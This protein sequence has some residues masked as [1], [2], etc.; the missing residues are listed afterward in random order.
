MNSIR[1]TGLILLLVFLL[2]AVF[3][4]AYEIS[5]LN[6]NEEVINQIYQNQLDAILYSV[7]Q[8]SDDVTS[9]WIS[10][11]EAG[12]KE[13]DTNDTI[14]EKIYELLQFNPGISYIFLA[15]TTNG[16]PP[17]AFSMTDSLRGVK[18]FDTMASMIL[19]NLEK[20]NRLVRYK[21]SGF[22]KVEPLDLPG[23]ATGQVAVAFILNEPVKDRIVCVIGLTPSL[24]ITET[25]S[26]KLQTIAR[27]K[28]IISAFEKGQEQPVYSTVDTVNDKSYLSRAVTKDF[29][30][31]PDHYLGINLKGQ[32]IDS[33]VKERTYLNLGLILVLDVVLLLG[34]WLAYRNVKREIQLAQNKA[35]FVSNVSHEIRT[36]LA[37]ISMFAETLEMDRVKSKEKEQE[38][39]SIIH[40]ET[41][42]LAGI[43]NKILNFSQLEAK[44]NNF[45]FQEIALNAAVEEVLST[46]EYHLIS[47]GFE[48]SFMPQSNEAIWADKEALQEVIINILDNAI[49]YSPDKKVIEIVTGNADSMAFVS[50]KDQGIGIQR[51]DQKYIF[52]KFYRVPSGDLAK[53]R[54]TG[55]GL[56]LV[57]QIVEAHNGKIEVKSEVNKGTTFTIYF[58]KKKK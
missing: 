22:Q 23:H 21:Q 15:D 50:V 47:K 13:Y 12:L 55:L 9:R 41:N 49:K 7:N 16:V 52:D 40:K 28:F 24:F 29:W 45:I 30:I 46:Y 3:Y 48:Y 51:K 19:R 20:I 34:V 58:P 8:Y 44:K 36:P 56:S 42:R 43:V 17:I 53:A 57:K 5:S 32:S 27:D 6:K 35:D 11:I 37:L 31:L 2:P 1:K 33:I 38:Y 25:L 18:A 39:I 14:P 10:K 26:A 4:S 54:G